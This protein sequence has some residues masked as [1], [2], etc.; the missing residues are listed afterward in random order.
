M[1]KYKLTWFL[2]TR[3]SP[4]IQPMTKVIMEKERVL[5][6]EKCNISSQLAL[7]CNRRTAMVTAMVA[8]M[9]WVLLCT[10]NINNERKIFYVYISPCNRRN[11]ILEVKWQ[12]SV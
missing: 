10:T 7:Q 8:V 9:Y 11:A 6:V 5:L 1:P 3:K 2:L 12:V 4:V